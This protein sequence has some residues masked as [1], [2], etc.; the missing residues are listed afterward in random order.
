MTIL[1]PLDV[2]AG[3]VVAQLGVGLVDVVAVCRSKA[4]EASSQE[5][6]AMEER[7]AMCP[8]SLSKAADIESYEYSCSAE[9]SIIH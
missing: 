1:H 9:V 8:R 7:N 2:A 4:L 5:K 6:V 3:D